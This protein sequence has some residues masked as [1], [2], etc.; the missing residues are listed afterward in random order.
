MSEYQIKGGFATMTEQEIRA[1]ARTDPFP[2][3][4][5][6]MRKVHEHVYHSLYSEPTKREA[7]KKLRTVRVNHRKK[8]K[9]GFYCPKG[10][11]W[12]VYQDSLGRW[13]SYMHFAMYR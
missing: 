6:G 7:W 5:N 1:L 9:E 4:W 10:K 3:E 12:G 2:K 13:Y 8:N 11:H